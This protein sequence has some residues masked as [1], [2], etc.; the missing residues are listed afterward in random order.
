MPSERG[1]GLGSD[2]DF[3][4]AEAVSADDCPWLKWL[5]LCHLHELEVAFWALILEECAV[6][7]LWNVVE[8]GSDHLCIL[9]VFAAH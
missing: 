5:H 9:A 4:F 2:W 7:R 6:A 8:Y 1:V 3:D